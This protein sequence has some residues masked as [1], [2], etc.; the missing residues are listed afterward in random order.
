MMEIREVDN[1][2]FLNELE[3]QVGPVIVDF[4]APWCAPCVAG[5]PRLKKAAEKYSDKILFVKVNTDENN[6]GSSVLNIRSIPALIVFDRGREV[7]RTSGLS[8]E[9]IQSAIDAA[10]KGH[11]G[12]KESKII[13]WNGDN[14]DELNSRVSSACKNI[15]E[16]NKEL[17][18]VLSLAI[19]DNDVKDLIHEIFVKSPIDVLRN[20]YEHI[21]LVMPAKLDLRAFYLRFLIMSFNDCIDYLKFLTN[22]IFSDGSWFCDFLTLMEEIYYG[23]VDDF[24]EK[25]EEIV[26]DVKNKISGDYNSARFLVLDTSTALLNPDIYNIRKYV[27]TISEFD[28]SFRYEKIHKKKEMEE[29]FAKTREEFATLGSCPADPEEKER[30]HEKAH[31]I[32]AN[33]HDRLKKTHPRVWTEYNSVMQR[34]RSASNAISVQLPYS[35]L[36]SIDYFKSIEEKN[37]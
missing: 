31:L 22:G 25:I 10:Q 37:D 23:E 3:H 34:G 7:F 29:M 24:S 20:H 18:D 15:D 8:P 28:H 17:S 6:Y 32:I 30:H 2:F 26:S 19:S 35:V 13:I 14:S 33:G 1:A 4:W 27:E 9:S 21:V 12:E 16:I 11:H 5:L 36:N